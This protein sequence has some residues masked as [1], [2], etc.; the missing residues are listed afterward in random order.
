MLK[1]EEELDALSVQEKF[2]EIVDLLSLEQEKLGTQKESIEHFLK[3]TASYKAGLFHCYDLPELPRTNNDLEQT[4]GSFRHHQRRCTG[5]K[6]AP[7]STVIRGST[8][9]IAAV[10]TKIRLFT[11]WDLAQVNQEQW[12]EIRSE[13]EQINE[14]RIQQRRFRRDPDAYLESL[15]NELLQLI[16]P[17]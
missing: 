2:E 13:L 14:S 9:L 11:Q 15:E 4:F 17:A 12:Q 1:N 10:A 8:R 7:R 6:K 5:Q 16:L 3:V